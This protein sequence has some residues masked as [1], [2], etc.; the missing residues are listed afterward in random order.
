MA[1]REREKNQCFT[2]TMCHNL[3][4]LQ[5]NRMGEGNSSAY[6]ICIQACGMS[7]HVLT[8]SA[9]G[10]AHRTRGGCCEGKEEERGRIRNQGSQ[11]TQSQLAQFALFMNILKYLRCGDMSACGSSTVHRY[12]G[13]YWVLPVSIPISNPVITSPLYW[14]TSI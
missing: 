3:Q 6:I 14:S 4:G 12:C 9:A 1:R 5:L 11:K 10:C 8:T 2:T 7:T 13:H